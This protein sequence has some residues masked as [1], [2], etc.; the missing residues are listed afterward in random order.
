MRSILKREPQSAASDVK[1]M[2]CKI[3]GALF[4]PETYR[5]RVT[6]TCAQDSCY[7]PFS[8]VGNV[9]H[10]HKDFVHYHFAC[11]R[12]GGQIATNDKTERLCTKCRK[13]NSK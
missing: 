13:R 2:I 5:E 12:C 1:R 6:G 8:D 10:Y 4:V 9:Q 7:V 11:L 3:C